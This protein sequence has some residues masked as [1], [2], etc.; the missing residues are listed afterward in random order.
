MKG[1]FRFFRIFAVLFLVVAVPALMTQRSWA[2][3]NSDCLECHG[4]D[5]FTKEGPNGEEISLYVD[6]ARFAASV[7]GQN[8][9]ACVDCHSDIEKLNED[10]D[11]PHPVPLKPVDCSQCHDEEQEAYANSVHGE[12]REGGDEDAPNCAAC[13]GNHYIHSTRN[14]LVQDREK[15]FCLKCHNAEET[16]DWLPGNDKRV[17]FDNLECSVCHVPENGST[18]R[19]IL[20][21]A[22][23][24]KYLSPQEARAALGI[25]YEDFLKKMDKNGN[26]KIDMDE[27]RAVAKVLKEKGIRPTFKGE[28]VSNVDPKVHEVTAD[29]VQ[30]CKACHSKDSK[31]LSDVSIQLHTEKGEIPSYPADNAVLGSFYTRYFYVINHNKNIILDI[32]GL[33]IVLGGVAFAGG[34]GTIRLLTAPMRRKRKEEE[35]EEEEK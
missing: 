35:E 10:E 11:V 33:L 15:A 14:M 28:V 19:L 22:Y 9:V 34:H 25:S 29:A 6:E 26:G 21:N 30:D 32:I 20:Y 16:H 5:S 24:G 2:I 13:H 1:L 27:F 18:V 4:D 23:T 12:A 3:E 17:H 7:H 8:E 31:V